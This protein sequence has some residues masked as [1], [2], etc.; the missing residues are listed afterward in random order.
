MFPKVKVLRSL[1]KALC[2][3]LQITFVLRR[4][5]ETRQEVNTG[6]GRWARGANLCRCVPAAPVPWEIVS[7]GVQKDLTWGLSLSRPCT[8]HCSMVACGAHRVYNWK[9]LRRT[10]LA[11]GAE[12][13]GWKR[14]K[15]CSVQMDSVDLC[16]RALPGYSITKNLS[17]RYAVCSVS[18]IK[19]VIFPSSENI[20]KADF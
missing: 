13:S 5:T 7:T 20:C 15:V 19:P 14:W 18:S 3:L 1:R 4:E 9:K 6:V 12:C 10:E 8:A 2:R 16:P 17:C 11:S